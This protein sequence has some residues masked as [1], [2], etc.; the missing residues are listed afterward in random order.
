[1]Q[2]LPK[3]EPPNRNA[4]VTKTNFSKAV[5]GS[6]GIYKIIAKRIGVHPWTMSKFIRKNWDFCRPLLEI[7]RD[8]IIDLAESAL[9]YALHERKDWA[10]RY[11]LSNIG[12]TRGWNTQ[13][14]LNDFEE[15]KSVQ[16]VQAELEQYFLEYDEKK[17]SVDV[18]GRSKSDDE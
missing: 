14:T 12:Q 17:K 2:D 6:N 11:T 10:I 15:Q 3:D 4:K 7:E 13:Q 1:M 9:L 5:V 8:N 18:D 16:T